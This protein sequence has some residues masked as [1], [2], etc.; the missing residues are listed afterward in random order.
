MTEFVN[1][2][3]LVIGGGI[4]QKTTFD[5]CKKLSI[6][7]FLVDSNS[8]CYS[9]KYADHFINIDFRD[10]SLLLNE[11]KVL[12]EKDLVHGVFTQGADVEHIVAYLAKELNFHGMNYEAAMN[13]NNKLRCRKLL[14]DNNVDTTEYF[15]ATSKTELKNL[16]IDIDDSFFPCFIKPIN[17]CAS[18][19]VMRVLNKNE[20][21]ESFDG[22][23]D[24]NYGEKAVLVEKEIIGNEISVDSIVI[25]G[26]VYPCGIS[27]R[28]F[29]DKNK[30]AVQT[31]SVTPSSLSPMVQSEVYRVMQ[32]AATTLKI[33]NGAF[34]GDL[35][36][37]ANNE[38]GIIE[39]A[40]RTSGGF[41]SQYRK[42]LSF[43]I[44]I[45]KAVLHLSLGIKVDFRDLIPK[46]S[47]WSSTFSVITEAGQISEIYGFDQCLKIK[48]VHK[49]FM[50]LKVGDNIK[51]MMDCAQR[52]NYFIC[53]GASL[54]ELKRIETQITNTLKITI[55]KKDIYL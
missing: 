38:V 16:L 19:G 32:K 15:S 55:I 21:L 33:D 10:T 28:K 1:K 31:G 40:G 48:G 26:I 18:R 11:A 29:M 20:L 27:D 7:T 13:C 51:E 24:N 35:V 6:T 23:A 39:L 42:P 46:W 2:G 52:F 4:L 43:G 9:K 37:K 50:T 49:G 8:N 34:K 47:I 44:D 36:I 22:A 54:E 30:Y 17:N 53:F 14:Y 25:N 12:K 41:D 3:I 45:I 5:L